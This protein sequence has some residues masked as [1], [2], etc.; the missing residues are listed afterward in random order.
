MHNP[1]EQDPNNKTA[2]PWAGGM[3]E[4][5]APSGPILELRFSRDPEPAN[6][7]IR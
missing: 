2:S 7:S 3:W 5:D 1:I 6:V 4:K